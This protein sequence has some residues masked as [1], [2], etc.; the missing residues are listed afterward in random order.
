MGTKLNRKVLGLGAALIGAVFASASAYAGAVLVMID[1]L[2]GTVAV[3]DNGAG[4]S[5]ATVGVINYNGAIGAWL[6]TAEIGVSK[7]IVGSASEAQVDLLSVNA[8][9]G[10]AGDLYVLFSDTDFISTGGNMWF[11]LAIGGTT[12]GTVE[13]AGC[14]N[15]SNSNWMD[16]G[17]CENLFLLSPVLNTNPFSWAG[18]T[19]VATSGDLFSLGIGA[20]ISHDKGGIT[21]FD[22]NLRVPEPGMLGFL[23][24]GLLGMGLA[25]RRRRKA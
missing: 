22:A 8:S 16:E 23:G 19:S 17:L 24:F 6:V 7:P 14:F 15:A 25:A 18:G 9:S 12:D 20:L 5:D 4:D 10:A 21:S 1:D 13:T 11:D 3:V 2:G